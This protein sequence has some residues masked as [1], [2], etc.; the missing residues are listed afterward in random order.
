MELYTLQNL[1]F[2][3]TLHFVELYALQNFTLSKNKHFAKLDTLWNFTPSKTSHFAKLYTLWNFTK[4]HLAKLYTL[5]NFTLVVIILQA[6]KK[7][8]RPYGE[9]GTQTLL[10][11]VRGKGLKESISSL[12]LSFPLSP[13]EKKMKKHVQFGLKLTKQLSINSSLAS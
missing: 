11:V 7:S 9:D 2:C 3:K 12:P 6:S 4:L 5:W 8:Q 10:P 13:P 1:T